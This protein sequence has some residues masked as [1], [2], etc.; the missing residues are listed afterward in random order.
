[1][2]V[3]GGVK[4]AHHF[5]Q[6]AKMKKETDY[7][8]FLDTLEH[9][10]PNTDWPQGLKALWYD[11]KG[12]WGSAHDIAE[13]MHDSLGSWIHAYLHRKEGDQWNA[14]YWYRRANRA[15][16]TCS[17]AEEHKSMVLSILPMANNRSNP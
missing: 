10:R 9:D 3:I 7:E 12:D 13:Q 8:Q 2:K 16:A 5:T 15:V 14:A 1:M 4:S 17:L 11:A 6:Y